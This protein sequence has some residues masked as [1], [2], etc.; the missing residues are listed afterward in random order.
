MT[1][2]FPPIIWDDNKFEMN[3]LTFV[4]DWEATAAT[5]QASFPE[6]IIMKSRDNIEEYIRVLGLAASEFENILEL[7]VMLGGS[8]AFFNALLCPRNHLAVDLVER[9]TGLAELENMIAQQGRKLHTAF[10]VYQD[11]VDRIVQLF[12][13]L[14]GVPA[15]FDLIIDDASHDYVVTLRSFN[16]LFP[17]LRSGGIYVLE[18]WGWAHWRGIWQDPEDAN[19]QRPAMSNVVLHTALCCT[20]GAGNIISHIDVT[21]VSAYVYRGPAQLDA[22]FAVESSYLARGKTLS[23]L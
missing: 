19:F 14:M 10:G 17:R 16:R 2:R 13:E 23:L 7:G 21:P 8:C 11:D 1:K 9:Q 5:R 3:G 22:R 18:D 4:Q 20:S 15:S 12:E 6:F